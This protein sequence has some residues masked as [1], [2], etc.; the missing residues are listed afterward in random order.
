MARPRLLV[1]LAGPLLLAGATVA[2][3]QAP[4]A[5]PAAPGALAPGR[6]TP[7][8]PSATVSTPAGDVTVLAD[9]LEQVGADNLL[10]ATGNVEITRATTRITADRAE[11]NRNTGDLVAT[12]RV[13]LYDVDDRITGERIDYNLNTGTGVVHEGTAEVPPYYRLGGER[14]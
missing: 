13:V 10:V 9:H 3:A 11:I 1:L 12:G 6:L 7:P 14:M 4:A 8:L 2:G 5:P